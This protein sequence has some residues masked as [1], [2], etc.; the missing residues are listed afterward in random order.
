MEDTIRKILKVF[1]DTR[2]MHVPMNEAT[3]PLGR[4]YY[5]EGLTYVKY[6]QR[7]FTYYPICPAYP[8]GF[9]S[10][11][12]GCALLKY[13][14]EEFTFMGH[15]ALEEGSQWN[16]DA[17]EKYVNEKFIS[18]YVAFKPYHECFDPLY[19][20]LLEVGLEKYGLKSNPKPHINC[21]GYIDNDDNCYSFLCDDF[22]GTWRC[23]QIVDWGKLSHNEGIYRDLGTV[24]L[25]TITPFKT[26][27]R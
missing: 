11:F 27:Q 4:H 19:K 16:A 5:E 2:T 21:I 17:W 1:P 12:S 26:G 25:I 23:D 14:Q 6:K 7:S 15:L 8:I 10:D 20:K 9:S 24:K 3:M 13:K 22:E 18:D